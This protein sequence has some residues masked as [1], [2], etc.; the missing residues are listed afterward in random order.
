MSEFGNLL[1][2]N[3]PRFGAMAEIVEAVATVYGVST[4][5]IIGRCRSKSIAEARQVACLIARRCTRL[6]LPEIGRAVGCDHT[7]VMHGIKAAE[8]KCAADRWLA[9]AV[10]ELLTTFGAGEERVTQ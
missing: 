1:V 4:A 3:S 7:T 2:G 9:A 5:A 8:Q 10:D 6:S